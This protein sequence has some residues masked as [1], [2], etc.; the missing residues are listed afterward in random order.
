MPVN[1]VSYVRQPESVKNNL[2]TECKVRNPD[3]VPT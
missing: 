1:S 2:L 3:C